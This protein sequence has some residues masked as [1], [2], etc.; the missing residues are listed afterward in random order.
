M[1]APPVDIAVD[2]MDMTDDRSLW[3]RLVDVR[4]GFVPIAGHFVVVGDDDAEP[5]VA[6]ILSVDIEGGITLKVL[7]GPV[8]RHRHL[9]TPS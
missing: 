2:F 9:L 6:Q 7:D 4:S 1:D 8:D 3:A 5:A